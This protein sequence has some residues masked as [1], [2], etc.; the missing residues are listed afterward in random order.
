MLIVFILGSGK[1]LS[2][3]G[4]RREG[5]MAIIRQKVSGGGAVHTNSM[6]RYP[7]S[8]LSIT[9]SFICAF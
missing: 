3:G 6:V 5:S 2:G 1:S 8:L 9:V 4:R 7:F